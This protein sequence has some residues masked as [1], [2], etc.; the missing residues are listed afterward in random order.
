MATREVEKVV[1]LLRNTIFFFAKSGYI[2][3]TT[4]NICFQ[5]KVARL[6]DIES[7]TL[8]SDMEFWWLII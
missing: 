1:S 6:I 7:N 2:H 3:I 4:Q 5:N 8:L